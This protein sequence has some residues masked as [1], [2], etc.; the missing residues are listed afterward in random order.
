ME[1]RGLNEAE[2]I[3]AVDIHSI[4]DKLET[5]SNVE[6]YYKINHLS[7]EQ[8]NDLATK[9]AELII[10]ELKPLGLEINNT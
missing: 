2:I 5:F 10:T 4:L 1:V 3:K 8:I 9:I 6:E 7:A